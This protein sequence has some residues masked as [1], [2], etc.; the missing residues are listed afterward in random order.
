[1]LTP[2]GTLVLVGANDKGVWIGPLLPS[3]KA[4]ALSPFVSQKLLPFL[5]ELNPKD[6]QILGA[7]LERGQVKPVIDRRYPLAQVPDALRYLEE[8]HAHGK[9]VIDVADPAA[10]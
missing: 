3:L 10:P 8:G 6:L 9:V 2:Q 5:A 1:M 4:L 7:M